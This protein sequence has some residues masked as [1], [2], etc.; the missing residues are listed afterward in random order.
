MGQES[1]WPQWRTL[2]TRLATTHLRGYRDSGRAGRQI[3]KSPKHRQKLSR[4][5]RRDRAQIGRVKHSP[6]TWQQ[7]FF[8]EIYK[9]PGS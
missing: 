5:D 1:G 8:P 3:Q 6:D 7:L 4:R 2:G 9:Q